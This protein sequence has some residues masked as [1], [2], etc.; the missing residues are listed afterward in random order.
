MFNWCR[1]R[2]Y[3]KNTGMR[4]PVPMCQ[5]FV[6]LLSL[7]QSPCQQLSCVR[8]FGILPSPWHPFGHPSHKFM[9]LAWPA[10]TVLSPCRR[11]AV[12]WAPCHPA[13]TLSSSCHFRHCSITIVAS[14]ECHLSVT[15]CDATRGLLSAI[16][17]M[18]CLLVHSVRWQAWLCTPQPLTPRP[19]ETTYITA[20]VTRYRRT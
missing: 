17:A 6:T 20:N 15:G 2:R 18:P 16:W 4:Y 3:M 7:F 11:P 8:P 9:A 5:S 13:V 19:A 14:P 12:T 1:H 10:G